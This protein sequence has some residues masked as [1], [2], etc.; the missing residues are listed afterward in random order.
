MFDRFRQ[1]L[2]L[3]TLSIIACVA[4]LSQ[5]PTNAQAGTSD[6]TAPWREHSHT[7]PWVIPIG[8]KEYNPNPTMATREDWAQ[9][10][11]DTFIAMNWPKLEAQGANPGQPDP[12]GDIV[13]SY[14]SPANY[15]NATWWSYNQKYQLFYRFKPGVKNTHAMLNP[16]QWDNPLSPKNMHN[17]YEIIGDFSKGGSLSNRLKD[18]LDQSLIESPLI[19]RSGNLVFYQIFINQSLWEYTVRSEYFDATTQINDVKNSVFIGLPKCACPTDVNG[20]LWYDNLPTYAKQGAMSVKVAWKQLSGSEADSGRYYTREVYYENNTADPTDICP[21]ESEA[22]ITV[23][24]VGLHILRLTPFTGATWFWSSFEHI[25]NVKGSDG[26]DGTHYDANFNNI[27]CAN[28]ASGYT[29][30]GTCT[31]A[32][33][34]IATDPWLTAYPPLPANVPANYPD[35]LCGPQDLSSSSQIFRIQETQTNLDSDPISTMNN[36]YQ[37]ALQGTPWQYYQ[38]VNTTQPANYTSD[39]PA[40]QV[41]FVPP[42]APGDQGPDPYGNSKINASYMTNTSME[43]YSQYNFLNASDG[44]EV[45]PVSNLTDRRAMNCVTC[46]SVSAP[47][48]AKRITASPGTTP[49]PTWITT[50][51]AKGHVIRLGPPEEASKQVFT[52]LLMGAAQSCPADINHDATVDI[53]DLMLMV[54]S[55]GDCQSDYCN[56]DV[57]QD[58]AADIH[59]LLIVI[60][61]WGGCSD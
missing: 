10:G 25:D 45:A 41:S 19:D 7:T 29:R 6:P 40:G 8:I 51:D 35:G 49:D 56:H 59:D 32:V 2:Y 44:M 28:A 61:D 1:G 17:G 5:L 31:D 27:D 23:G 38:Q 15:P 50:Y 53:D 24:L 16:G 36:K 58:G 33:T 57:N 14:N 13:T 54:N 26:P 4:M 55:W 48:G 52:F 12:N 3:Q 20:G 37:T 43:S 22:P 39:T 46:H 21:G 60:G 30:R 42:N 47:V 11:W 9:L 34:N 18:Q